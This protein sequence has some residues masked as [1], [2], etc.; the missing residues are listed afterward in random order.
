MRRL[1]DFESAKLWI[2]N[3]HLWERKKEKLLLILRMEARYLSVEPKDARGI[4]VDIFVLILKP[5]KYSDISDWLL[6]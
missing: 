6:N 5:L 3:K 4:Y 2:K 1:E